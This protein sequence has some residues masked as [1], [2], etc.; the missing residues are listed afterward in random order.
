M[1]RDNGRTTLAQ[2]TGSQFHSVGCR[3]SHKTFKERREKYEAAKLRNQKAFEVF[4]LAIQTWEEEKISFRGEAEIFHTT[5]DIRKGI[6]KECPRCQIN[7]AVKQGS[8][9]Y[10]QNGHNHR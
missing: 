3:D 5:L 6:Q 2:A 8:N 4:K 1:P 7:E 9:H 10:N